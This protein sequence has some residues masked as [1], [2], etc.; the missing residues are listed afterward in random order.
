M[1]RMRQWTNAAGMPPGYTI[2]G[3]RWQTACFHQVTTSGLMDVLGQDNMAHA[4]LYS[5]EAIMATLAMEPLTSWRRPKAIKPFDSK[6]IWRSL[7]EGP[8][9]PSSTSS[10]NA[11][12]PRELPCNTRK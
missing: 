2:H 4:A 7:A 12:Q 5:R 6:K 3:L 1:V 9:A 11:D 8:I 10:I